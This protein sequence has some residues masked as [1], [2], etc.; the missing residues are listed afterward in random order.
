[1]TRLE[2][3]K[4]FIDRKNIN[5]RVKE[6]AAEINH[7][8]KGKSPV[9]IGILNGVFIFLSDLVRELKMNV[10]IDF[11]K[12]ESYGNNKF[13][14]GNIRL[15]KDLNTPLAGRDVVIVEDIIDSGLS[16]QYIHEMISRHT[17]NSLEIAAFLCK[18]NVKNLGVDIKYLGF[19]IP[20][21]FVVGYGLDCAQKYRN[22]KSIYFLKN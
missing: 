12:I 8:Y 20:N 15:L 9:F 22:L 4:L 16:I 10:E 2:E 14:T 17:P 18:K 6:I 13:S 1:M 5:K 19:K 11:I 7:D 21:K 3:L